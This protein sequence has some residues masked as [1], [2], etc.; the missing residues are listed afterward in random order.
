MEG[1]THYTH[2]VGQRPCERGIYVEGLPTGHSQ[3]LGSFWLP[4]SESSRAG[5]L[6]ESLLS[7]Y[8]LGL[9]VS[10]ACGSSVG[11]W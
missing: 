7:D 11:R 2:T 9:G 10:Q 4:T 1:G 3:Y 5:L 6:R 8:K